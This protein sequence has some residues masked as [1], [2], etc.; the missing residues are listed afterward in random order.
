MKNSEILKCQKD[1]KEA[2]SL[3]ESEDNRKDG[4][5]GGMWEGWR[6][7]KNRKSSMSLTDSS[8]SLAFT[9][10]ALMTCKS[11]IKFIVKVEKTIEQMVNYVIK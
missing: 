8:N 2:T 1:L 3:K 4:G 6:S 10:A 5:E 11:W 9:W 7:R